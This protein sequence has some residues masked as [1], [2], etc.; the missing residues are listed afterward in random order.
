VD[1]KPRRRLLRRPAVIDRVGLE[2]SQIYDLIA[3]KKFPAPVPLGKRAVAWV[4]S[5]IDDWIET[6]IR[7]RDRKAVRPEVEAV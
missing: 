5:E 2:T 6:K 4:E 7:E 3:N 1:E